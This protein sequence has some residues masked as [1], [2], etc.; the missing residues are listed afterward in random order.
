MDKT[1]LSET[2]LVEFYKKNKM[3][4]CDG[5]NALISENVCKARQE[6][7][8]GERVIG[9]AKK[10]LIT[11][12]ETGYMK[13]DIIKRCCACKRFQKPRKKRGS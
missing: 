4:R 1:R 11:P 9:C 13:N 2:E 12:M 6:V 8:R 5:F 3:V 10:E 7:A